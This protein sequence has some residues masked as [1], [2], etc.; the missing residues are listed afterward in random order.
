[1]NSFTF[2]T[3]HGA[4]LNGSS[5]SALGVT[6]SRTGAGTNNCDGDGLSVDG[7]PVLD[8]ALSTRGVTAHAPNTF[9]LDGPNAGTQYAYADSA[10][11][12]AQLVATQAGDPTVPSAAGIIAETELTSN[13]T[14]S[15]FSNLLSQTGFEF[16][17]SV[18]DPGLYSL[19]LSF[20]ADPAAYSESDNPESIS[21]SASS[22]IDVQAQ[23]SQ[24]SRVGGAGPLG[25]AQWNPDGDDTTGCLFAVGGVSCTNETDDEDLNINTTVGSDPA[26]DRKSIAGAPAEF[27]DIGFGNFSITFAG[28]TEGNWS[29]DLS[30][31]VLNTVTKQVP[32]PAILSLMGAGL[33]GLG[34]TA[35]RRKRV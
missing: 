1:V 7:T 14:G 34:A 13:A 33:L 3:N 29:F 25:N 21:V 19:V 26:S 27:A 8:G 22:S 15:G 9:V 10:I 18:A 23:L 12:D 28:L 24:D 11:L 31:N 4:T 16:T 30:A 20:E 17:F 5:E 35:R 6:C 2:T 32:S